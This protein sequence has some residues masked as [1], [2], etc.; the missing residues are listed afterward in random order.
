[1]IDGTIVDSI[2]RQDGTSAGY[3]STGDDF[4]D[5]LGGEKNVASGSRNIKA[6]F[7][8]S[9]GSSWSFDVQYRSAIIYGAMKG[10]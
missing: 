8:E 6:L 9:L 1:V 7:F 3:P 2:T 10:Q 5:E 4:F